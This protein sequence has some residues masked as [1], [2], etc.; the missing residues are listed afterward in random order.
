VH[1]HFLSE[2]FI[3]SAEQKLAAGGGAHGLHILTYN[4]LMV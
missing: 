4:I 2:L 1:H 3:G